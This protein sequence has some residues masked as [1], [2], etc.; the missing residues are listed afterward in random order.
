MPPKGTLKVCTKIHVHYREFGQKRQIDP[1]TNSGKL[2]NIV[3]YRQFAQILF[4][5]FL[6][7]L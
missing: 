4:E 6:E 1:F 2:Q 3:V 5:S 7:S